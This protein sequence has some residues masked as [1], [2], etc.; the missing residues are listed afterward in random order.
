[1][2]SSTRMKKLILQQA[3]TE[4][5]LLKA[6]ETIADLEAKLAATDI[7]VSATEDKVSTIEDSIKVEPIKEVIK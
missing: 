6:K 5:E 7:K 4:V 3:D 2:F 1:M